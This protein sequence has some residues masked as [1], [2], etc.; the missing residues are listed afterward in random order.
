MNEQNIIY[1]TKTM[2]CCYLSVNSQAY[3]KNNE[4]YARISLNKYLFSGPLPYCISTFIFY[5]PFIN[6]K[7]PLYEHSPILFY[8]LPHS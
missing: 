5:S 3:V 6:F 7:L 4:Q 1:N 2:H 8:P